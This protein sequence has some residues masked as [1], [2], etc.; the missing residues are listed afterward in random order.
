MAYEYSFARIMQHNKTIRILSMYFYPDVATTGQLLTELAIGL[1]ERGYAVKVITA[2]PTYEKQ[3]APSRERYRGID[4]VRLWSTTLNKNT[5]TGKLLNSLSFFLSTTLA[6]LFSRDRSPLLIVSNPPFLPAVGVI[7][8]VIRGIKFIF[9]VHDVYPDIA[10]RLGYLKE[11]SIVVAVWD[12]VNSAIIRG[13]SRIIVLSNSMKNV[14]AGKAGPADR[15][16]GTRK[17]VIIHNWAD[18]EFIRPMKRDRNDF[19]Q[20]HGL[21]GKFVVL[22]SGNLGLFHELE[23]VVEAARCIDDDAFRFVFIGEGG[24]KPLLE[25]MVKQY[26]LNNVLFFPYQ[27]KELLPHSLTAASVS[28]VTLEE[29]IEGLAMPS[30]LYTIMAAGN[31]II[32][33]CDTGSDVSNIVN[34]ARCGFTMLHDDRDGIIRILHQ[35]K[36]DPRLAGELGKNARAYFEYHFT[37]DLAVDQYSAVIDAVHD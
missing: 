10:V 4:I 2:Q 19:L 8:R 15:T 16:D 29:N 14:I 12:R 13:A 18:G 11:N 34:A 32:G 27:E 35:L 20:Q 37:M 6:L 3:S 1:T 21:M 22:Y 31:P 25:Q 33:I 23:I 36:D 5:V 28:V 30:K 9:L 24:K 7:L 26:Q 17:I